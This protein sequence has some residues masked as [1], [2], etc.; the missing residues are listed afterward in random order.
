MDNFAFMIHPIE[1][2]D[3]YRKFKFMEI[4]P[5]KLVEKITKHIPPVKVSHITGVKSEYN[6]IEG[7]FVGCP[8]LPNKWWNCRRNM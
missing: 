1:K 4:L 6:E 2:S 7:W 3:Y 8:L 5:D